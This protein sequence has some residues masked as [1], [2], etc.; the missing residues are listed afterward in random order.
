MTSAERHE[1]LRL[2]ALSVQDL[3]RRLN[4]ALADCSRKDC[5]DLRQ[6]LKYLQKS[7]R[8]EVIITENEVSV[9]SKKG[10]YCMGSATDPEASFRNHGERDGKPDITLGYNPQV[11]AT[12]DGLIT[13]TQ[14]HTGAKTDQ[15]TIPDLITEQKEH[16]GVCRPNLFTIKRE[17][18]GRCGTP[19]SGLQMAKL[20]S[21]PRC[22]TTP[23]AAN[24]L[25]PTTFPSQKMGPRSLARM[26]N[27][28]LRLAYKSQSGKGRKF[29]FFA[30]Q[31]WQGE[32][33]SRMK[34]ADLSKRC[35]LWEQ[36][37]DSKQGPRSMRQVFI[38]DY[39]AQVE[40]AQIYNQS[41]DYQR[42]HKLRQRIERVVAELVRY[43]NARRCRRVGLAPADWQAK[44]AATSY[45]LKWWMRRL[46]RA[47]ALSPP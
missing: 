14:A 47:Q 21:L 26:E 9:R 42:D 43:N 28:P 19:W 33:P 32:P 41:E 6:A 35:P 8:D 45:N 1:R 23:G 12:E 17:A 10:A 27:L 20:R 34:N 22:Q 24:V 15:Q 2:T 36:C 11:A 29:R 18:R 25:V 4:L 38:S 13:E 46:S 5:A 44:M 30:W 37:R 31:C 7:L 16:H 40:A 3:L 39:R